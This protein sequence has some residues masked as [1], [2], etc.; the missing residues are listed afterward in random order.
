MDRREKIE[1]AVAMVASGVRAAPAR[2]PLDCVHLGRP[3]GEVVECQSCSGT[4]RLKLFDCARHGTATLGKKVAGHASCR[5]CPDHS[6]A[7]AKPPYEKIYQGDIITRNL[8]YYVYPVAGNGFWQRRVDRL[9]SSLPL[10]NGRVVVGVAR[11]SPGGRKYT[12][13][14]GPREG[15]S[16]DP[17]EAVVARFGRHASRIEFVPLANDPDLWE[18]AHLVPLLSRV[19]S[20]DPRSATLYAHAKGVTRPAWHPAHRWTEVLHETLIE[21]W[22]AVAESLRVHPC[23]GSFKKVGRGWPSSQSRSRWH[24]SGSWF[25]VRDAA[26]LSRDWRKIDTFWAAAESYPSLHFSRDEAGCVFHAASVRRMNLYDP[27]YWRHVVEPEYR[28]TFPGKT[29]NLELASRRKI[30]ADNFAPTG[31]EG[32]N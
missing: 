21:S 9:A 17:L 22:D 25:W 32:A 4:V 1:K 19:L 31:T 6:T 3:T 24:Y 15:V 29:A 5:S 13:L 28:S 12:A 23:A 18:S 8:V 20:R 2:R 16:T 11:E 14:D 26:L 10:F 27:N 7:P 30:D